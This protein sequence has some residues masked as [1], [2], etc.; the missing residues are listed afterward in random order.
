MAGVTPN[1]SEV[2]W[3]CVT[4]FEQNSN[5]NDRCAHHFSII[6]LHLKNH[7]ITQQ[8]KKNDL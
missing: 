3:L 8:G 2:I 1:F 5:N 6:Y 7:S 4:R